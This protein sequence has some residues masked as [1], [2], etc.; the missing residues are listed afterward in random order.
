VLPLPLPPPPMLCYRPAANAYIL[1]VVGVA[2]FIAGATTTFSRLLI[3]VCAPA[4]TVPAG[5]S[6]ATV[7]ACSDYDS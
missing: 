2:I 5:D 1:I 6:V 4:I 7:V 3:V